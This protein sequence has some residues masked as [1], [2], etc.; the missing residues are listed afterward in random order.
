[1][2]HENLDTARSAVSCAMHARRS[3]SGD[4]VFLSQDDSVA[5]AAE[6]CIDVLRSA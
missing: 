6:A 1:M 2:Y 3:L 5:F 4:F